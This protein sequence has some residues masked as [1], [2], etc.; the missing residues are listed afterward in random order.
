MRLQHLVR[1]AAGAAR[2]TVSGRVVVLGGALDAAAT[3]ARY[4]DLSVLPWSGRGSAHDMAQSL[5]FGS[6]RPTIIVPAIIVPAG[7][8]EGAPARTPGPLDHIAVAWD[9]SPVAARALNDALGLL[10]EGGR[11]SVLTVVD[12]KPLGDADLAGLLATA[13]QDRSYDATAVRIALEGR[14]IAAA[15]QQAVETEGA[16]MLVMGGFGHSRLR[17][18]ILGGATLGVL[19]QLTVPVL[20]SH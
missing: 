20:L 17:D 13:L 7:A 8:T 4:A 3:E 19:D 9:G 2:V 18:F 14:K 11:V 6:G 16:Q 15:L 10:A 1:T 5:V 12:E